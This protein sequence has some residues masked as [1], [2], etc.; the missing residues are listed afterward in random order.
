MKHSALLLLALSIASAQTVYVNGMAARAVIGQQTFTAADT[1]IP[2]TLPDRYQP[3]IGQ[4]LLGAPSGI[5]YA[6]GMLFVADSNNIGATPNN[7]RVLIYYDV[8]KVVPDAK[9]SIPV[10]GGQSP[11]LCPVCTGVYGYSYGKA[12]TV[13]GQPSFDSNDFGRSQSAMRTPTAVASDGKVLAVADTQNNRVLIWLKIPAPGQNNAPADVVVGNSDFTSIRLGALDNKS[14]L[15]PQGVW[16]QDG[17]LFIADTRNHRVMV[18]NSIPTKNDT[19]AD[20]VLG[21]KDFT[22]TSEQFVNQTPVPAAANRLKNPVSVTSDGKRLYIADLGYNRV[23][24]WNTIPTKTEQPAE[25]VLGQLD[26]NSDG[27]GLNGAYIGNTKVCTSSG[28][29]TAQNNTSVYPQQCEKTLQFPRAVITDGTR[30]FVADGGSDRVLIW[31]SIPTQNGQ[32]ADF[33][34]GQPDLISNSISDTSGFFNPNL[35]QGAPN[36]T[37]TPTGLAWDGAN[38]Y[39]ATPYDRRILAFTPG[40]STIEPQTGVN[41]A[42]SQKVYALGI[43]QFGGRITVND[44]IEIIINNSTDTTTQTVYDYTAAAG[45]KIDG[46]IAAIANK[47]NGAPDPYVLV[48]PG[49][50]GQQALLVLARKP[51]AAGNSITVTPTVTNTTTGT[52]A[53]ITV[54]GGTPSGG[55]AA[56]T[57]APGSIIQ[58]MGAFLAGRTA[59][60]LPETYIGSS[61]GP[62]GLPTNLGGVEVYVDGNRLPL[63][64]VSP[65]R[66]IAQLPYKLA[67]TNASSLYVRTVLDDGTVYVSTAVNLPVAQQNPG[68]FATGTDEPRRAIAFHASSYATATILIDGV[69]AVG[70]V[71]TIKIDDRTYNYTAVANDTNAQVRDALIQ[72]INSNSEEKVTAAPGGSFTRIRLFAK[73]AGPAGEGTTVS[74]SSTTST[75]SPTGNTGAGVTMNATRADL[76]CSSVADSPITSDNPAVAGETI[77]IFAT[78]IGAIKDLGGVLVPTTE[79]IPYNGPAINQ[80]LEPLSSLVGGSSA[81]VLSGT[82]KPG[83]IGIYEVILELNSS[84]ASNP[85]AQLTIAQYVYVSNIVTIPI[86]ARGSKPTN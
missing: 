9:A 12:G 23:L 25:L 65:T 44:K 58:I 69:T 47:I 51:G 26:M 46:V 64:Y 1:P 33:V 81:N 85:L 29:D 10:P 20:Y 38:L 60:T 70:D 5:A 6:K 75:T 35:Q 18:W 66:I 11:V 73:V 59:G 50:A 78:G 15:G 31:N 48:R 63:Y 68:I 49:A 82:L 7:N 21:Q 41:N 55:G 76:C 77:K 43:M 42:A 72:K 52:A 28:V 86:V 45:D 24:I 2:S 62:N 14:L 8:K 53:T 32:A 57:A 83:F 22:S 17:R 61:G 13:L 30:L 39:V 71:A 16:I 4:W 27:F 37:K 54:S 36:T 84:L 19:P 56:D 80:P 79:G 74:A 40:I 34:L 3:G 67:N